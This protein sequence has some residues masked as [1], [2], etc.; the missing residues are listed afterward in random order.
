MKEIF[1]IEEELRKVRL[2]R[3]RI[4]TIKE[5]MKARK[6]HNIWMRKMNKEAR[7]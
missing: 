1:D 2:R 4:G 6:E 3:G 7:I 5:Q